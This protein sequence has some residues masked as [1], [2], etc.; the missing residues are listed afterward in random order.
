[1][2]D[3]CRTDQAISDISMHNLLLRYSYALAMISVTFQCTY[4]DLADVPKYEFTCIHSQ[5]ATMI[6]AGSVGEKNT[7]SWVM[8]SCTY[9]D[10]AEVVMHLPNAE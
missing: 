5:A 8:F 6:W 4:Q 2:G 3:L 7:R 10:L 1:M 9:Q